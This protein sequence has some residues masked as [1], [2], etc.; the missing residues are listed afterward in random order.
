M[1][2]IMNLTKLFCLLVLL[3]GITQAQEP[4]KLQQAINIAKEVYHP[5]RSMTYNNK[6]LDAARSVPF[7]GHVIDGTAHLF[8]AGEGVSQAIGRRMF[9]RR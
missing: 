4:S 9:S 2:R 7:A 5:P 8:R 6:V 3:F 1:A